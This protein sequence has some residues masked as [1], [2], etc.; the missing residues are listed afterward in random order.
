MSDSDNWQSASLAAATDFAVR[1]AHLYSRPPS[2]EPT[3]VGII[4]TLMT[5]LWD[6]NFSQEEIRTAFQ[7]A[8]DDMPCYA[9]GEERRSNFDQKPFTH[10]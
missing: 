6:R 5:E 3:L 10:F 9:A 4:N 7:A 8:L 2:S 1:C